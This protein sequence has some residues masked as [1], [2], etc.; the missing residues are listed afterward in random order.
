MVSSELVSAHMWQE[1]DLLLIAVA[2][3]YLGAALWFSFKNS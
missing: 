3:T 2:L 1:S